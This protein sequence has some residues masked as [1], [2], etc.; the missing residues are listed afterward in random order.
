[1]WRLSLIDFVYRRLDASRRE[2]LKKIRA[3]RQLYR[4]G[5]NELLSVRQIL[6]HAKLT[7]RNWIK[8]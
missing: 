1:M 5:L 6:L 8:C 7:V 2:V 3:V 4:A